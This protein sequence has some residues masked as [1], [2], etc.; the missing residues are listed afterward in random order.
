MKNIL[1]KIL[2]KRFQQSI[3]PFRQTDV[4]VIG[5]GSVGLAFSSLLTK[6]KVNHLVLEKEE[7]IPDHPKAHYLSPRTIEIMNYFDTF[8]YDEGK[9]ILENNLNNLNYWSHYRYCGYLLDRDSYYGEIDHFQPDPKAKLE[10]I[11][12]ISNAY[13]MH[14]GQNK[15]NKLLY[16][17]EGGDINENFM[18]GQNFEYFDYNKNEELYEIYTKDNNSTNLVAKSKFIVACDGSHSK[19]RKLLNIQSKGIKNI[20]SFVNAHFFSLDLA[21]RLKEIN[22]QSM[23]HFIFNPQFVCVLISY[24]IEKGEFVMQIPYS[25]EIEKESSFDEN[26]CR[27]IIDALLCENKETR[28][29]IK[30]VKIFFYI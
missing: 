13:P 10:Y 25:T 23:L 22:K 3:K 14:I 29:S 27:K 6:F 2:I 16:N 7:K 18:K 20:Q 15:L 28:K 11:N 19:I 9:S 17:K 12:Q 26:E 21:K 5:G 8:R 4:C 24:D 30:I 1:N